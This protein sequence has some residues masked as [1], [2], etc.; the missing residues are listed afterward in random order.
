[1]V[2]SSFN[3]YMNKKF[4]LVS[5]FTLT[6]KNYD[7]LYDTILSVLEQDY[8]EFEYII[9]DDGS[10]DF[11]EK[12]VREFVNTHRRDN[13][14]SFR[15]YVNRNNIG[16]VRHLNKV[17]NICRGKYLFDLGGNDIYLNNYVI[18]NIVDLFIN[19]GCDAI[20]TGR[21]KYK[22]KKI[23]EIIPHI[24]D[25][26]NCLKLNNPDKMYKALLKTQHYGMF[27][28]VNVFYSKKAYILNGGFDEHY[29]LLEDAPFISK[30]IL[31]NRVLLKPDLLTVLYEGKNGVSIGANTITK[32]P[33][34]IKDIK[35]FNTVEKMKY[36][37]KLDK[38]TQRHVLFGYERAH[39]SNKLL[40]VY[41]YIKYI[42][43][44]VSFLSYK[45][46]RK[47]KMFGDLEKIRSLDYSFMKR[48]SNLSN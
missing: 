22:G 42:P 13:L 4:P 21:V 17:I 38:S 19:T 25:I 33:I 36:Y 45:L 24:K 5:V 44:I 37:N 27:V 10:G 28:G 47:I 16:T 48:D 11:P 43:C 29:K 14:K 18:S 40:L 12:G 8:P 26:N 46:I 7:R 2:D 41:I 31:N 39:A 1:M 34:L 23:T 35:Y 20:I 9:S 15:L 6:Y 30:I 32:N 3:D